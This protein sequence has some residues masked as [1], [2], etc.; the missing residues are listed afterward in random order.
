MEEVFKLFV[1]GS[2]RDFSVNYMPMKNYRPSGNNVS[3]FIDNFND[4]V[5]QNIIMASIDETLEEMRIL[6][7]Y[8]G[9]G[10]IRCIVNSTDE[11]SEFKYVLFDIFTWVMLDDSILVELNIITDHLNNELT[12]IF[13]KLAQSVSEK[14]KFKII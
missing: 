4:Y 2:I 13:N 9:R 5:A 10:V 14:S 7:C 11:T 1:E 3:Y 6:H 12:P 8:Y